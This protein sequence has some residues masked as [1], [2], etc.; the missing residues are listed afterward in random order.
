ML[1]ANSKLPVLLP[2]DLHFQLKN[3][4]FSSLQLNIIIL[5]YCLHTTPGHVTKTVH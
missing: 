4:L 5:V 3:V 1:V 2:L